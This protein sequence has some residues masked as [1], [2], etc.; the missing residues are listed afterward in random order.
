MISSYQDRLNDTFHKYPRQFWLMFIGMLVSTIGA[1]MIWPFLMIYVSERLNTPMTTTAFLITLNSFAGL[2]ASI[3]AG[4]IIDRFGRKWM[5]VGSLAANGFLYLFYSHASTLPQFAV[6]MILS[7]AVNP[8][9]RVGAD[10]MMADLVSPEKRVDAYSLLRLSNNLGVSLGPMIGGFIA[11]ASYSVVFF[12]AASGMVFYSLLMA[13]F[14]RET[15]PQRGAQAGQP[16]SSSER[17]GGYLSILHDKPF[18]SFVVSFTMTAVCAALV[19]VLMPIYAKQNYQV[20]ENMYGFIPTTNAVMVVTLQLFVTSITRRY[21]PLKV[22]AVGAFFYT[23]GVGS[24]VLDHGFWGFW[25]SMVILSIGELVLVPTASTY[26]ANMAPADK[27]GRYM[28]IYGMTW[29][30][31]TM[32]GPVFGGILNDRIGPSA[33]WLGGAAVGS[34]SILAFVF[35][36]R[37][38]QMKEAPLPEYS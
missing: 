38:A 24:V 10:A 17:F 11:S 15:L 27:R 29:G 3:P 19:W 14:G 4:Q 22:L 25:I 36:S 2:V 31:S 23:L 30:I 28:S 20:P 26:A 8:L 34:I 6:L 21:R 12:L 35:L 18:I 9:F 1:S 33:I 7:G 16:T 37:Q 32:I 5:M 13:F